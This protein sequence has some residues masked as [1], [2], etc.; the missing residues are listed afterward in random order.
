MPS[1]L[2]LKKGNHTFHKK[3]QFITMYEI[4]GHQCFLFKI[5]EDDSS[6]SPSLPCS[7]VNLTNL[8]TLRMYLPD[9]RIRNLTE[10]FR[11]D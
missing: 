11:G 4:S 5:I 3:A 9:E 7:E 8:R 6:A 2:T 10:D 1:S